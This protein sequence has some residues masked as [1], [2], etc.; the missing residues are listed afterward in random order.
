MFQQTTRGIFLG[1]AI[2]ISIWF[3]EK[4][5]SL[6]NVLLPMIEKW[7]KSFDEGGAFGALPTD[8]SKAFD[9]FPQELLI[10]KLHACGV[11]IPSLKLLHPYLT[12]RK[13]EIEWY[14]QF[15][16]GNYLRASARL[17][18]WTIVI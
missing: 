10:A 6:I 17:H 9:C 7:R 11:D 18:T 16:V 14:V 8:L 12:K 4:L 1:T 2:E 3:T 5:C 15:A 13:S